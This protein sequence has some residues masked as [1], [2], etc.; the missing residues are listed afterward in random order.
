MLSVEIS[1]GSGT[2]AVIGVW[3]PMVEIAICWASLALFRGIISNA[4]ESLSTERLGVIFR[5]LKSSMKKMYWS[6]SEMQWIPMAYVPVRLVRSRVSVWG[7]V[8]FTNMGAA[9]TTVSAPM[10]ITSNRSG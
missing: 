4:N 5:M 9:M 7:V 1:K 2:E 3:T 8:L 10:A 6:A